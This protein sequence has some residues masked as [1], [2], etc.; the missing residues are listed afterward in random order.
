MR[1]ITSYALLLFGIIVI[2]IIIYQL[3]ETFFQNP[4]DTNL[5]FTNPSFVTSDRENN[6][7]VIDQSR[8]RIVKVTES[9]DVNFIVEGGKRESGS[10]FT[11]SELT[12]D[13]KGDFYV[14]NIVL[15]PEG[16]YVQKEEILRYNQEGKFSNTVYSKEYPENEGPLREG[17]ISSLSCLDGKIYCYFKGQD[18]VELYTIPRDGGSI[19]TKKVLFLENARVVLVDIKGDGKGGFHYTTKKGDIYTSDNG[20]APALRYTVGGKDGSEGMSIPWRLNADSVGN[21]YFADLG[22]R[23]IRKIDAQSGEVSDLISSGSLETGDIEEEKGA[24]Y[25]FAIGEGGLFTINGE[26]VIYQSKPGTIDFCRDSVRYPITVIVYRF[27]L[28]L[29]PLVW[30]GILYVLARAIYINLM[31]RTVPRMAGQIVFILVAVS[32]TAA[33]VSNMV[34]NNMLDRYEQKVMHNLSQDVQLAASIFDGDKIQRIERLDQFMNEDYNS[35]RDQLYKFFN[36]NEDPWNSGQYGVIYK[37]LDNKVYAL[38]FYDDSIGAFY[39]IDFD[40]ENSIYFPVYDQGQIITQKDSDADGDW[41]YT[42]GPLYNSSGE[43]VAMVEMGTDLFGFKEE[44]KKLITNIILDVATILVVLIFLLT[45]TSIFMGILS[46][47]KRR[48]ESAGLKG[49]IPGDGA[50]MVRPLGFLLFTG[51]FMSVSFIPVLMKDLYQPVFNLPESVVLGLPISAEMLCIALFSVLAGYM[52]DAKGWKPVFL[53]GVLV[54]G[55]GTLLSGL[56]HNWLL[57]IMARAL[58]GAGSGL[59][60]IA[61]ENLAMS[62]PTDEGK[63]Q[64]LSGLTS[65]VFSGMNVGVAVGAML[66]EWA[67]FSNV[68][69]VALG[70]VALA[71]LFAYKIMPNFK[72]HSGEI[73]EKMSLAKV[74]KF[75]GNVNVFAFF[76]LIFIPVSIC[77]MFLSYFFPV[78]AEGAGVSSSNIGRAF[79]LNGLCIVYLGPFLT[80]HISKYLGARKAVLVFTVLVAAAILLFAHQGSVASAYVAII[81]MGIA[82]SFGITLLID[83]FTELRATSELGHGKAMGYYSLVE[84]LGQ[85]MGPIAL[86]FVTILGNQKGMAIVG[87]A[88]LGALVLFMLLSRK[89]MIVRYKERGHTC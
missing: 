2:P 33:V 79:I 7:Y 62:A 13:E 55:A 34:L 88:L 31:Q 81:I 9:G 54:L 21:I 57:F 60:I 18:D 71:G 23:K 16:A 76:L 73:S 48:R 82:D 65:G 78:F 44:N 22:Q 28:W 11:A 59:A 53:T 64:G 70:M 50:Y 39:P 67:G 46:G 66:A 72:A 68:F 83:Y 24:F 1:K 84:Y 5:H 37:V 17:W 49:L 14:L 86:G 40:Y 38:M 74:G 27:L 89:E 4:F 8:K 52:I 41:M 15:D 45:E 19:E 56:T 30:L 69:F 29:L 58:A 20:G 32:L 75:F 85:M 36:N 61:L 77:G 3:M 6:M 25:Q 10:F 35:T 47:R 51:S 26:M 80:K 42:V 43:T 87:G 63:N 12:V